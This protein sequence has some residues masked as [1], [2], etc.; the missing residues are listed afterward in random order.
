MAFRGTCSTVG[1]SLLPPRCLCLEKYISKVSCENISLSKYSTPGINRMAESC[2]AVCVA[3]GVL[4]LSPKGLLAVWICSP[5]ADA[6]H[7][8][9]CQNA[10]VLVSSSSY[11]ALFHLV[12]LPSE[13]QKELYSNQV[14]ITLVHLLPE[15]NKSILP[16]LYF[17]SVKKQLWHQVS[18]SY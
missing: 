7:S 5:G 6:P 15:Y 8:S 14:S 9:F 16:S 4:V 3:S 18:I 11:D 17:L 1:F 2:Q 10:S 12:Y 13:K